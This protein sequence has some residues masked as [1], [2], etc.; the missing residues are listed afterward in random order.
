MEKPIK[1]VPWY[2]KKGYNQRIPYFPNST[3]L[4]RALWP[5]IRGKTIKYSIKS[6][7]LF[8]VFANC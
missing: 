5:V 1:M 2:Q 4:Y 7:Y 6:K 3:N 8:V